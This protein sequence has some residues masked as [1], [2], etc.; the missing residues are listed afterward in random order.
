[1]SETVRRVVTAG[2]ASLWER[3]K[4]LFCDKQCH[5][6]EGAVQ[7]LTWRSRLAAAGFSTGAAVASGTEPSVR[8][9]ELLCDAR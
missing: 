9:K 8:S 3:S 7:D 5:E 1:M 2:A 6:L 4:E